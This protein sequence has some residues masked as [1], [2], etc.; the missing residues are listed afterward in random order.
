MS[1]VERYAVGLDIGTTKI[2][3]VVA[4]IANP[5]RPHIVSALG[6]AI[7]AAENGGRR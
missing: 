2:C 3:C 1:K 5:E 7:V 4:D 6:A